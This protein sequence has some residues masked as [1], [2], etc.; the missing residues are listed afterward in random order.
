MEPVSRIGQHPSGDAL[1]GPRRRVASSTLPHAHRYALQPRAIHGLARARNRKSANRHPWPC[2]RNTVALPAPPPNQRH[3]AARRGVH[4]GQRRRASRCVSVFSLQSAVADNNGIDRAN[5]RR[6]RRQFFEQIE[7]GLLVGERDV[8]SGKSQPAHALEIAFN[9]FPSGAGNF[10][11]L[12]VAANP[13][14]SAARSCIAGAA[15]CAIGAPSRPVRIRP[16]ELGGSGS[17][18]VI[19]PL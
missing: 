7:H 8:N 15:D 13:S 10:D 18:L 16:R 3:R 17:D 14:A 2:E 19:S 5:P 6:L 12:I 4:H 1:I 11:E 9:Y